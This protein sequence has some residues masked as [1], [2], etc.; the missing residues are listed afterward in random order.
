MKCR[1]WINGLSNS[2][3]ADMIVSDGL[4]HMACAEGLTADL[5]CPY[6]YANCRQC[7]ENF[8]E[9]EMDEIEK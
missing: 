9:S 8:L 2:D 7:I 6:D 1:E 4:F 5:S 3:F